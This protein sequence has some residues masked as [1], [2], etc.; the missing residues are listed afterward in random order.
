MTTLFAAISEGE[1]AGYGSALIISL[2]AVFVISIVFFIM[3]EKKAEKYSMLDLSIFKNGLFSLSIFCAFVSFFVIASCTLLLPYYLQELMGL[4][5]LICG[6]IMLASPLV[7]SLVAPL[8]GHAS[9]KMGSEFLTFIGLIIVAISLVLSGIFYNQ[10]T[11]ILVI[12][13]IIGIMAAG[14]AMFQ[15]PN[16][17]LIMS[18]VPKNKLGIAGSINALARNA[19]MVCG[20]SLSSVWLWSIMSK[21]MG[22]ETLSFIPSGAGAFVFA[23]HWVFIIEAIICGVGIVLTG[24]RIWG[25]RRREIAK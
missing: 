11:T 25:A 3:R 18:T 20:V 13:L 2:F 15:S 16:T 21:K 17:S 8:S 12:T 19:G 22:F 5:P 10:N 14:N 23:L 9:D 24:V 7:M 4:S 1:F 6:L